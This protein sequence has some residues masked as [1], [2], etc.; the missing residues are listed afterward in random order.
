[1]PAGLSGLTADRRTAPRYR[2]ES[3]CV[4]STDDEPI[5]VRLREVSATGAFVESRRRLDIGAAVVLR[6]ASAGD[7]AAHVARH[8]ADGMALQFT[9]GDQ[10]VGFALRAIAC[11]MTVTSPLYLVE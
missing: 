9:L 5:T 10:A 11:D 6:H 2:I 8:A 1:M 7:I 3:L 4:L